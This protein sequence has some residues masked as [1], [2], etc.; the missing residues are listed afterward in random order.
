MPA[1][2]KVYRVKFYDT[3]TGMWR[4]LT[5]PIPRTHAQSVMKNVRF[6]TKLEEV[7]DD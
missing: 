4:T 2:A 7:N 5:A 6:E 3:W 1:K